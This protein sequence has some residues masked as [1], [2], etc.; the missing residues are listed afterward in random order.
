MLIK[1]LVIGATLLVII[2]LAASLPQFLRARENNKMTQLLGRRLLFSALILVL[3][4][5]AIA[6]GLIQPNPSPWLSSQQ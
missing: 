6:T 3:V 4:I 1:L 5:V 2:S